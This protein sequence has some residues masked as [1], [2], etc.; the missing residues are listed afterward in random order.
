MLKLSGKSMCACSP[1]IYLN[2]L[3]TDVLVPELIVACVIT[4][5]KKGARVKIALFFKVIF[6]TSGPLKLQVYG[7]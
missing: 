1:C 7:S 4:K 3:Q 5:K 6:A 2:V